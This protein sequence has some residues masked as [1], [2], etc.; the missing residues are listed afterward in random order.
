MHQMIDFQ[1]NFFPFL[2]NTSGLQWLAGV[3][4]PPQSCDIP[5][6]AEFYGDCDGGTG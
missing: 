1:L 5:M 6:K 4:D 3:H 2:L